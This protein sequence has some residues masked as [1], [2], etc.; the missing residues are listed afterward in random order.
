MKSLILVIVILS[1][2]LA[3]GA[4][5]LPRQLNG[6][7]DIKRYA[8]RLVEAEPWILDTNRMD[9]NNVTEFV[10]I[11]QK[12]IEHLLTSKV[13][14]EAA[15]VRPPLQ[16]LLIRTFS[17]KTKTTYALKNK[18]ISWQ[19]TNPSANSVSSWRQIAEIPLNSLLTGILQSLPKEL[20]SEGFQIQEVS[21]KVAFAKRAIR[22]IDPTT[23][24]EFFRGDRFGLKGNWG[25]KEVTA[26][27][28]NAYSSSEL[29]MEQIVHTLI[30]ERAR[31]K[32]D[33]PST[34]N[35]KSTLLSA[36]TEVLSRVSH[37]E[38]ATQLIRKDLEL[39]I[40]HYFEPR[41]VR[42]LDPDGPTL[43]LRELEPEVAFFRGNISGNCA[44]THSASYAYS[45]FERDFLIEREEETLGHTS[46]TLVKVKGR[47]YFY[48]HDLKG[49][50]ASP[51][52]LRLVLLA[53]LDN[54]K[55]LGVEGIILPTELQEEQIGWG[56][57]D[58]NFIAGEEEIPLEYYGNDRII[59]KMLSPY[60]KAAAFDDPSSNEF[61]CLP[62]S[63]FE[64]S[65]VELTA[66]EVIA[67]QSKQN[68]T[69]VRPGS[70]N[71][72]DRLKYTI[73][74]LNGAEHS[75]QLTEADSIL[76]NSAVSKLSNLD[77]KPLEK[78]YAE[79]AEALESL[80]FK[81]S[82]HFFDA[83]QVLFAEGHFRCPDAFSSKDRSLQSRSFDLMSML[84]IS[85]PSRTGQLLSTQAKSLLQNDKFVAMLSRSLN[86]RGPG[87]IERLSQLVLQGVDI[88]SVLSENQQTETVTKLLN[89][90]N[91][92]LIHNGIE[93]LLNQNNTQSF[94]LKLWEKITSLLD[95]EKAVDETWSYRAATL[96]AQTET[97]PLNATIL[98]E[99]RASIKHEENPA[100]RT[101]AAVAL[102]RAYPRKGKL[103]P[104]G[105]VLQLAQAR[106]QKEKRPSFLSAAEWKELQAVACTQNLN[107]LGGKKPK[108]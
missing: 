75:T 11:E 37:S 12:T 93:Y 108:Q 59:R 90:G 47:P 14:M 73:L 101:L 29:L 42:T 15:A 70:L 83:H 72:K 86:E 76:L 41:E 69:A 104:D 88:A 106:L 22:T 40:E 5:K 87:G 61:G 98:K 58:L 34:F 60:V 20:R 94:D 24:R 45:P 65:G 55:I 46:G 18:F 107:K 23:F 53:F 19:D 38:A 97:L 9:F 48:L 91:Q 36:A 21:A 2:E 82:N 80:G 51:E 81:F 43:T 10:Q 71:A 103:D 63:Q 89:S 95:N 4:M 85:N 56:I 27:L 96:M 6:E 16:T 30:R 78:Y 28:D 54:P 33:S 17:D 68:S 8:S 32:M 100:I 105:E 26:L 25:P 3:L 77:R 7:N 50:R 92:A 39:W 49:M 13:F 31:Q 66:I 79:A 67:G 99:L 62:N 1:V 35:S 44:T 64:R 84:Y 57:S 102:V 52:E 74:L